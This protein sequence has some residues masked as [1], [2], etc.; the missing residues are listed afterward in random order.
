M[1]NNT[2]ARLKYIAKLNQ[3]RADYA[4]L[5]EEI[6]ACKHEIKF[7]LTALN[8]LRSNLPDHAANMRRG[9]EIIKLIDNRSAM[10]WHKRNAT[11]MLHDLKALR[12]TEGIINQAEYKRSQEKINAI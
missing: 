7:S 4:A 8:A 11:N 12:L 2:P 6:R 5:T 9:E 10:F 1:P 3:F